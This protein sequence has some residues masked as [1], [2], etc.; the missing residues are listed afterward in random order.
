MQ[1]FLN[2]QNMQK[3]AKKILDFNGPMTYIY[4]LVC[5]KIEAQNKKCKSYNFSALLI[6]ND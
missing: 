3:Y 5:Y 2:L 6:I 4:V 1:F